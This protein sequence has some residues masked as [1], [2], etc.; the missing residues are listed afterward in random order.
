MS[1]FLPFH[2]PQIDKEEIESVV[3]TLQSGWLTTGVKVKQFEE[4]FAA[5]VGARHAIAVNSCTA[6][7]HLALEA[8]GVQEDDEVILPTMTFAATAEV[9]TYFKAKPVL[10]DV[11]EGTLNIDP[12]CIEQAITRKTK[13][14]IP[15]HFAGHP[16]AMDRILDIARHHGLPL[17]EDAAH[18][19]PARF[20]GRMVGTIG[21]ITCFSFYATKNVTT[22]EGGMLTTNNTEWA[23]RMRLMSLHGLSRDAWN[24]YTAQGAWAYDIVSAGFKYNLTDLAAAVGIPQL[25]KCDR[26][27][28]VRE[29]YAALYRAGLSHL[30]EIRLPEA[31][32]DVQH[33]WHLFVIQLIPERL[34]IGRNEFIELLKKAGVGCSVHFIPL[35][36]HSYYRDVWG[37]RSA[38]FPVATLA[39][40]RI[41]SLPLYPK[42]TEG[43]VNRVITAVQELIEEY[44]L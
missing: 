9:A 21:D 33:A 14:I 42:M 18:A 43:D 19:L 41:V 37:Y 5:F 35:H 25:H 17:I 3:E 27:W 8:I 30:Q 44:R 38:D 22:G 32:N 4:E 29:R 16:C 6:A 28:K 36:L 2:V 13:A 31:T 23:E 11:A 34:R 39:S 12:C 1:T 20:R 24:R 10:V 15:V 26:F 40:E 7:L